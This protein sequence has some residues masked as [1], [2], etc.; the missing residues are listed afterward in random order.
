MMRV[1]VS[2]A[3]GRM[4]KLLLQAVIEEDDMELAGAVERKDHPFLNRDVGELMGSA[5][6]GILLKPDL[7]EVI[8]GGD[9]LVEFSAPPATL[10][11]LTV[12]AEKDNRVVIGTTG[13]S[14]E[15]KEKIKESSSRIP[16]LLSPNMSIG[17]NVLFKTAGELARILGTEYDVEII[18]THHRMKKDAPSGTALRLA[19]VIA[20][21]RG[22]GLKEVAV[23][24]RKGTTG[25][26][27]KG[28]IGI[29]AVRGGSVSGDHNVIFAGASERLELTHRA[30]SRLVFVRG[31][32]EAI[33]FIAR[34][35]PGLYDM[36]DVIASQIL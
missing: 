19:E 18:E 15:K 2:G 6:S 33:R 27:K 20:E 5:K 28:A 8:S 25:E 32:I 10:S 13:L 35:S 22:Q 14:D 3:G 21:A 7:G 9:I 16:V 29:H 17:V 30:E 4:G 12:A 1:V 11:H 24:G 23:Y 34:A 31:A 26:R 36:Q